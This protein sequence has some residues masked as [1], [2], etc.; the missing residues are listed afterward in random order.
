MGLG[1]VR[2]AGEKA[3]LDGMLGGKKNSTIFTIGLTI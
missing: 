2:S 1:K 3:S